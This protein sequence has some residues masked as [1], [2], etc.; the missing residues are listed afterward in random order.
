[1]YHSH[2]FSRMVTESAASGVL[3]NVVYDE[4]VTVMDEEVGKPYEE[5]AR[6]RLNINYKFAVFVLNKG[7]KVSCT[8]SASV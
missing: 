4:D 2:V 1:M 6:L 7:F 3:D 5:V 8:D